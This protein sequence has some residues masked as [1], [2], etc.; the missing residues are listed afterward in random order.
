MFKN[1]KLPFNFVCEGTM[2]EALRRRSNLGRRRWD[3]GKVSTL[4]SHSK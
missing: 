3:E 1:G 2:E 4:I